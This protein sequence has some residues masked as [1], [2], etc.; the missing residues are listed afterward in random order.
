MNI[1][2][3]E[4]RKEAEEMRHVVDEVY[5]CKWCYNKT[6]YDVM[7]IVNEFKEW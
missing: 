3:Y 2:C 4:C 5:M 7:T 6:T 1:K